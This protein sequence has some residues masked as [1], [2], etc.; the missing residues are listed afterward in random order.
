MKTGNRRDFL[1]TTAFGLSVFG[2]LLTTDHNVSAKADPA[3]QR[4]D[5]KENSSWSLVILPDTQVYA[6]L[7]PGLF[8]LQTQWILENK[9]KLNIVYALQNGD[10]TDNNVPNQWQHASE[11][12][13]RLDGHVPYAISLGNH[14]FGPK[15]STKDRTTLANDYFP[16]SRFKNMPTFGGVMEKGKIDNT[17]HRFRTAGQDYL[18]LCFEFGPRNEV[19]EW[20]NQI[21]EKHPHHKVIVMTHAYLYSDSSRYDWATK[22]ESQS[23]NPH[24][25]PIG[26]SDTTTVNDGQE[27]WDKLIKPHPN[28][29]MTINGHVLNDGLGYL[30]SE[31][32]SGNIVHQML[33]NFQMLPVGGEAWLRILTFHADGK[34]IQ[35][36]DY[37][38]LYDKFNTAADNQFIIPL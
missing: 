14:D 20:A 2:G 32:D 26:K 15:G 12:F 27:M 13:G 29:F 23:W 10:V 31:G 4:A 19:L 25:Y 35:V 3:A 22:G 34:S 6:R 11:A 18:L 28:I 37:S 16:V 38:P 24:N 21:I 30:V 33:V 1:K 8:H 9:D 36:K 17:F 5:N 7:Y